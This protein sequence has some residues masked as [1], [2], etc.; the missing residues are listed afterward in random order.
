MVAKVV[1]FMNAMNANIYRDSPNANISF[2]SK[3]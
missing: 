3:D 2:I 1:S